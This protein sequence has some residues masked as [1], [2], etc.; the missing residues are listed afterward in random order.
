MSYIPQPGTLPARVVAHLQGLPP[1]T[2]LATGV[3]AD[4]LDVDTRGFTPN[5][6]YAVRGG[7]LT[8]EKRDGR[9][10]WGLGT[11]ERIVRESIDGEPD[12]DPIVQ[13]V[14]PASAALPAAEAVKKLPKQRTVPAKA[15][16]VS[17][18]DMPAW[19]APVPAPVPEPKKRGPKPR[20]KLA[21]PP[22]AAPARAITPYKPKPGPAKLRV[23]LWS[24][25]Q[26]QIQRGDFELILLAA[27][28]TRQLVHYLERMGGG[29]DA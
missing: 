3:L 19:V 24:D 8:R 1:G 10:Y 6:E 25:G 22:S 15:T 11:G 13:R 28:E 29:G 26:L 5:L 23:A 7:L 14:I 4:A 9:L 2:E 17:L 27:D 21:P 16:G 12:D 20:A 18:V